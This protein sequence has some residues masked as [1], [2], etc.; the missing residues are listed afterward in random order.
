MCSCSLPEYGWGHDI[1]L[2]ALPDQA[3][4]SALRAQVLLLSASQGILHDFIRKILAVQVE[5]AT[6]QSAACCL[7]LILPDLWR[8]LR[9]FPRPLD[10]AGLGRQ[11]DS[12]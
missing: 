10:I 9:H 4:P 6:L 12:V 1:A 5:V 3:G 8:T 11:F 2:L 7:D